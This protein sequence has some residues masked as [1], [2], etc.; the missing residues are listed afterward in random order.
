MAE[1]G[2][3]LSAVVGMVVGRMEEDVADEVGVRNAFGGFVRDGGVKINGL[4]DLQR[5]HVIG[6]INGGTLVQ[7]MLM[8]DAEFLARENPGIPNLV[9]IEHVTEQR[10]TALRKIRPM[11]PEFLHELPVEMMVVGE[12]VPEEGGHRVL[13]MLSSGKT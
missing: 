4:Q 7:G 11:N 6:L 3:D 5:V 2:D 10:K 8:L 12:D 9:G 13:F 1:I